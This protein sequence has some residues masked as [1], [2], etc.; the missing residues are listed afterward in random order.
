MVYWLCFKLKLNAYSEEKK[1]SCL[2]GNGS[3]A[4]RRPRMVKVALKYLCNRDRELVIESEPRN[5]GFVNPC[6]Q[7]RV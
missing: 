2:D 6:T 1:P 5:I 3:Q 4:V 7:T